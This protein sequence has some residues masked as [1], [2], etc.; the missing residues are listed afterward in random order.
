[1]SQY[2]CQLITDNGTFYVQYC[3]TNSQFISP[4]V[5]KPTA[6]LF[7]GLEEEDVKAKSAYQIFDLRRET[8]ER[9]EA[10][11]AK[12]ES[13]RCLNKGEAVIVANFDNFLQATVAEPQHDYDEVSSEVCERWISEL[14][15]RNIFDEPEYGPRD[16]VMDFC[17]FPAFQEK[18]LR[19]IKKSSRDEWMSEQPPKSAQNKIA[20]RFVRA[21]ATIANVLGANRSAPNDIVNRYYNQFFTLRH[22]PL[23]P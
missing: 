7:D 2:P 5:R 3:N 6:E 18:A 19:A 22:K 12:L 17:M 1:M 11:L 16:I 4:A 21:L 15:L 20:G 8:L 14:K 9:V 10:A 23:L 13:G